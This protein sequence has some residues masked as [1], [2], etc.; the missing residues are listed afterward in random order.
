MLEIGIVA[1]SISAV[2]AVPNWIGLTDRTEVAWTTTLAT[3]G[4]ASI[5]IALILSLHA[6]RTHPPDES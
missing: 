4:G 1:L 3:I 6:M 5:V 2:I